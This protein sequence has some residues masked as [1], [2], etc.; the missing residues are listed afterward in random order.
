MPVQRREELLRQL[1][2]ERGFAL[3]KREGSGAHNAARYVLM[4]PEVM[5]IDFGDLDDVEEYL[6]R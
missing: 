4:N 5:S 2:Q 6:L 3:F 1:A